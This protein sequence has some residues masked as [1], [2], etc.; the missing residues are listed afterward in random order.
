[1]NFRVNKLAAAL[2]VVCISLTAPSAYAA[3]RDSGS[4]RFFDRF[5]R[6]VQKIKKA[7]IKIAVSDDDTQDF[8]PK[9]PIP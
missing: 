5:E 8:A 9:P 4:A 6:I 7:V 2:L 3:N 1:M